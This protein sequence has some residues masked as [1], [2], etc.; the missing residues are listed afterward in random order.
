MECQYC[1]QDIA[2]KSYQVHLSMCSKRPKEAEMNLLIDQNVNSQP[3]VSELENEV[4]ANIERMEVLYEFLR[5]FGK[6]FF[7]ISGFSSKYKRYSSDLNYPVEDLLH[8]LYDSGIVL[9]VDVQRNPPEYFSIIRNER[10]RLNRDLKLV[11]HRG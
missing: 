8:L 4:G 1:H 7:N 11:L 3:G 9:N 2:D 6:N 10:S 5:L